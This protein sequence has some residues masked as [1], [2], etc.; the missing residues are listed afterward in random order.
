MKNQGI[1]DVK[2][3][4]D[5][6]MASEAKP[7]ETKLDKVDLGPKFDPTFF[8]HPEGHPRAWVIVR[9]TGQP[10]EA[11]QPFVSLNGFAFKFRAVALLHGREK[12]VHVDVQDV[13]GGGHGRVIGGFAASFLVNGA[14]Q[15]VTR[16][17]SLAA[18]PRHLW[19]LT[20]RCAH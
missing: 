10:H 12:R 7:D 17:E 20:A 19:S 18:S 11:K 6:V 13:A 14:W 2:V 1:D 4:G 5:G 16:G 9:D 8:T 15:R 3:T